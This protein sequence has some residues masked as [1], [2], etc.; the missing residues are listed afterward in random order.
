MANPVWPA[1]LPQKVMIAGYQEQMP[2]DIVESVNDQGPTNKRPRS[3]A[4]VRDLSVQISCDD[5]QFETFETF[6]LETLAQGVLPFDWVHP[7]TQQDTTFRISG[8]PRAV[9][10]PNGV[11][12]RI[13]FSLEVMP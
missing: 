5:A 9:P 3:T 11:G 10:R 2:Q 1:S 7:R 4:A 6:F 12:Y 8:Q 13:A